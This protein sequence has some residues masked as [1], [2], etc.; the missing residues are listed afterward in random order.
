MERMKF[1]F[2]IMGVSFGAMLI[3]VLLGSFFH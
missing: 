3:V 1:V 2:S